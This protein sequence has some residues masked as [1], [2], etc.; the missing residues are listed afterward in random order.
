[1]KKDQKICQLAKE[2]NEVASLHREEIDKLVAVSVIKYEKYAFGGA[3]RTV[4]KGMN[5]CRRKGGK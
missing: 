1:M 2:L 3:C 4:G 5:E